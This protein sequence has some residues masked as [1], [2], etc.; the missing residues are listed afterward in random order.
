M[1]RV[2][3]LRKSL[4]ERV[5]E[6]VEERAKLMNLIEVSPQRDS[7]KNAGKWKDKIDYRMV[8]QQKAT[9]QPYLWETPQY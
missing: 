6:I 4:K 3:Q 2:K 5:D 7:R 9:R 8:K 1:G